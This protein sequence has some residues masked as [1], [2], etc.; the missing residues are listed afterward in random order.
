MYFSSSRSKPSR[1]LS[2][3]RSACRQ[4][5]L[6]W[7]FTAA[8]S[9]A[10]A[11]PEQERLCR[12]EA[13]LELSPQIFI[14]ARGKRAWP[15][16]MLGTFKLLKWTHACQVVVTHVLVLKS[17]VRKAMLTGSQAIQALS[18]LDQHCHLSYAL[19]LQKA[20]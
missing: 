13:N 16:I 11:Q 12:G 8:A 4:P 9:T 19:Y 14:M 17:A 20:P 15:N 3:G 6:A 2:S 5:L 18:A 7:L 1:S 10:V